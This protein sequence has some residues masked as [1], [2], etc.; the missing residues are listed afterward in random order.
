M[1]EVTTTE[2]KHHPNHQEPAALLYAESQEG[3]LNPLRN[4]DAFFIDSERLAFG[5][6]DGLGGA[7]RGEVASHLAA[8]YIESAIAALDP[9]SSFR[10]IE[11][12]LGVILVETSEALALLWRRHR[13]V[14]RRLS[15]GLNTLEDGRLLAELLLKMRVG[16]VEHKKK[17]SSPITPEPFG[18][19]TTAVIA[20]VV[21]DDTR[22]RFLVVSAVG[23]S[24]LYRYKKNGVLEQ[25][26]LD[27]R[28]TLV[29]A[30]EKQKALQSRLSLITSKNDFRDE[31]ER[32]LFRERRIVSQALSMGR[33]EKHEDGPMEQY[34]VTPKTTLIDIH[35]GDV[36]L[37]MTDG[38]HDNVTDT[39][40]IEVLKTHR[41]GAVAD[42]LIHT[43]YSRSLDE[44]HLRHH[45]DD[46]TVVVLSL[47]QEAS[48]G[49]KEYG[50]ENTIGP[51]WRAVRQ[52]HSKGEL[53]A[54]LKSFSLIPGDRE[55]EWHDVGVVS[56]HIE[57]FFMGMAPSDAIANEFLRKKAIQLKN[58]L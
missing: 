23:D 4:E 38:V 9:I 7:E 40:I 20:K 50:E 12:M 8:L 28:S 3:A 14:I 29:D 56:R 36:F 54:A 11:E 32:A 18:Y 15:R 39:E 25:C 10:K 58:N 17:N 24:R 6:F 21:S 16:I 35:E 41:V 37:A 42:A 46:M 55:H 22:K 30:P 53:L 45:P 13:Q 5:V 27:D 43:A 51:S 47:S 52:A 33:S 34:Q 57:D 26:T 44:H 31:A 2:K 48:P 19:G 49:R 1:R